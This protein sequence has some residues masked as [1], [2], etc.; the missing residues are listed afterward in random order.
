MHIRRSRSIKHKSQQALLID[1]LR[2]IRIEAGLRQVDLAER[3]ALPQSYVSKYE[4]GERSLDTLELRQV[5]EALGLSFID[6]IQRLEERLSKKDE[7]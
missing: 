5:C 1:L 4:T 6:F 2:D 7:T 3:L